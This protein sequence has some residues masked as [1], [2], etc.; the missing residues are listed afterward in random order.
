MRLTYWY[1]RCPH[2]S[3]AYSVRTRTKRKA[4]ELVQQ[5]YQSEDWEAPR[6]VTIEY[7]DAHDLMEMC[8]LEGHHHWEVEI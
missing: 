4:T 7:Q 8:S 2:D 1:S 5:A 3:D 6:K